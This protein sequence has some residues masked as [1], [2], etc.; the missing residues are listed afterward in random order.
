MTG[1]LV[2]PSTGNDVIRKR[3]APYG[4]SVTVSSFGRFTISSF[5]GIVTG[6]WGGAAA[7]S[8][9]ITHCGRRRA[10]AFSITGGAALWK[11]WAPIGA[12]ST[13]NDDAGFA[14]SRRRP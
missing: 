1:Y 7:L 4:T 6:L 5:T 2:S 11:G 9:T 13:S 10:L 12:S 3:V 8:S 14:E